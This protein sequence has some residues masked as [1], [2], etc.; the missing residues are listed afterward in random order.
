MSIKIPNLKDSTENDSCKALLDG[1]EATIRDDNNILLIGNGFDIALGK[2]TSYK[3]FIVY[4][5]ILH[6]F[7]FVLSLNKNFDE[8]LLFGAVRNNLISKRLKQDNDLIQILDIAKKRLTNVSLDKICCSSRSSFSFL[9]LLLRVVFQ[10]KYNKFFK[11]FV[12][13]QKEKNILK[14]KQSVCFDYWLSNFSKKLSGIRD[15]PSVSDIA[16]DCLIEFYKDFLKAAEDSKLHGWLDLE[17]LIQYMVLNESILNEQFIVENSLKSYISSSLF[18]NGLCNDISCSKGIFD[19]LQIFTIELCCF[20]KLQ[21]SSRFDSYYYDKFNSETDLYDI[22]FRLPLKF[23][24]YTKF[25]FENSLYKIID[26]NYSN[27]SENTFYYNYAQHNHFDF[28][29]VNGRSDDFTAV[30]GY[31][32]LEQKKVNIEAFN[33][34]K[35]TQRLIKNVPS[36]DYEALTSK[37][38]NLFI[39]GHSCSPA[40][41]DVFEPLLTSNNL[42]MVIVYSYSEQDKLSIYKNLCEILGYKIMDHLTRQTEKLS[43]RLFWA[44][45]K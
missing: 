32:N 12:Y 39:F 24:S 38:F 20:I 10:S 21:N 6:L 15:I 9:D 26:F 40:D 1:I 36:V 5:F 31:T 37:P 35:R 3:D 17:S 29:H 8:S 18:K 27:T 4:I 13:Y 7:K 23:N 2:K 11:D 42:N 28:Y 16:S 44:I 19:T 43:K 30:F 45:Q 33:F 34:E 22:D 25:D 41:K 14:I